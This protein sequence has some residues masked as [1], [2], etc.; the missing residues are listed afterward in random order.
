MQRRLKVLAV[1]D[2]E[3]D[4]LLLAREL[5]KG[6]LEAEF[7]RV[8]TQA[9]LGMAL[10]EGGWELVLCD[11]SMPSFS[12]MAALKLIREHDADVPVI[13][14]SGTMGEDVAVEAM[15]AGANDYLMKDNLRR[16]VPAVERELREAVGRRERK[17]AENAL[18]LFRALVDQVTDAIEVVDP[19]T[20]RFLDVNEKACQ[21]H[22]YSRAEYLKLT[23]FEIE[24]TFDPSSRAAWGA[25]LDKIRR[26]GFGQF[27]GLHRRKDGSVFPV[28]V[29]VHRVHLDREYLVAVARDITE[30]KRA[31]ATRGALLDLALSLNEASTPVQAARTIFETAGRLW[32]WDSGSLDLYS[33]QE[34]QVQPVLNF[35]VVNGQ[36][37]EVSSVLTSDKPPARMRRIMKDGPELIL[38]TPPFERSTDTIMFGDKARPSASI[39]AVPL[40]RTGESVGVLSVQSYTPNAF[41]RDD[42]HTL[43][44]L[45]D[46]CGGVLERIRAA[47]ALRESEARLRATLEAA[48]IVAW[49]VNPI[50]RQHLE[51]GPVGKVFGRGEGFAHPRIEDLVASIHPEDRERVL[52]AL[53]AALCGEADYAVEYRILL[54]D[55]SVRWLGANGDLQ[56]DREGRPARLLGIARDITDLKG[57]EET[58]RKLS[59]AVEQSPASIVITDTAGNIEYVNPKFTAVTGYSPEEALGKNPRILKSGELPPK[60]YRELWTTIVSGREWRGEFHNRKKSGE[61]YWES[62]SISPVR[63]ANG[64]I[65]HFLAVK[66]DITEHKRNQERIR[67]QAALLDQTQDAVLVLGLDQRFRY[68]NRSAE[69]SYALPVGQLLGQNAAALL[70]PHQPERCVEVCQ[71]TM[72]RGNWSG[73]LTHTTALGVRRI[74]LSRWTLIHDSAGQPASFLIVNTDVTEHKRLEEQFLRAQR[75]ESIGTLASGIAHDLNNILAPIMMAVELLR[76]LVKTPED[77]DVLGILQQS[78]LRG[79]GIIKQLLTFGRGVEGERIVLRPLSLLKEMA[80][81][82]RETF[83][84]NLTLAQQFPENLWAV[85]ADPTQFHQVLLN[86]C[87]NARDAMPRGGQ[88]TIAA[89]NLVLD[90]AYAATNPEAKAGPYVVLQVGDTGTGIALEIL[91]KIF[92]PFFTTKDVGKGTGLGLSTVLGIVKSHGGFVQVNSRMG[93]GTQFKVY[94]PAVAEEGE[95]QPAAPA[96]DLPRGEGEL[97]LVVDDEEAIRGMV[98]LALEANGYRVVTAADGAE[99]LFVWSRSQEPIRA[100]LT[101]ML[102]PVMDGAALIRALCRHSPELRIVAF[103]GLPEQEEE[104]LQ[105]GMAEGAFLLKPFSM[106]RLIWMLHKVLGR[107]DGVGESAP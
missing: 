86:L 105:A 67:Q 70:F 98:Q 84:K 82:V 11:F 74:E 15:R 89:E 44:G 1:E 57:T 43:Q 24:T 17:R 33:P 46:H 69:R 99:A 63:D 48:E 12:G 103:S 87:V 90:A 97:V 75:M 85:L 92:D 76:P 22:G 68:A 25:A 14:V 13:F 47:A 16:L 61:L 6:G 19:D 2:C 100:V 96:A 49:E 26:V 79:A 101:D 8:D 28:E 5:R 10:V 81:V 7:T 72:E 91:Q 18:A 32:D 102:M 29:R 42:L 58:L 53:Q 38:R 71:Q 59:R 83:P 88:L 65:T 41:T 40:R 94:L 51:A 60:Q 56:R 95:T 107:W 34:D 37:C 50:T 66:E 27:E 62:A 45:A 9:T 31:E 36:R 106:E 77:Q 73:E 104:A 55:G 3:D 39:M 80:K 35:D 21:F 30:R 93:Q 20:G 4:A 23:A 52:G 54:P 64:D 78:A